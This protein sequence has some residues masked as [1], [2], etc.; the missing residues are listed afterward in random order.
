MKPYRSAVEVDIEGESGETWTLMGCTTDSSIG[1]QVH[2]DGVPVADFPDWIH[3][4]VNRVFGLAIS[5]TDDGLPEGYTA[6]L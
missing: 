3:E 6:N 1:Y 2:R 5:I 4:A